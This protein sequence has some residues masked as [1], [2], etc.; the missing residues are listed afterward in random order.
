MLY[1]LLYQLPGRL[2][3]TSRENVLVDILWKRG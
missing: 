2:S 1:G 3:T